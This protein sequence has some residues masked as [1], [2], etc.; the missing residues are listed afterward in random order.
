MGEDG[1]LMPGAV[2]IHVLTGSGRLGAHAARIRGQIRAAADGC[3]GQLPAEGGDVDIVVRDDPRRVIPEVGVGGFAPD[4]HT[5]FLALDP[6]HEK[7]EW[8]LE[9]ELFPHWR[10]SFTTWPDA[11][12]GCAGTPFSTLS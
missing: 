9:R 6:G 1:C 7:F 4:G 5:V 8:A 3:L 10:T 2:A 12:P 11:K